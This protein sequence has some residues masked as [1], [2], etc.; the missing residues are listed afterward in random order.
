MSIFDKLVV[1]TLPFVPR[2]FVRQVANRY[3]AGTTLDDAMRVVRDLN[4]QGCMATLDVLGEHITNREEAET[5][6]QEYIK[7]LHRIQS[8]KVDSNISVK[9]TLL[10]LKLSVDFCLENMRRLVQEAK[11][12]NNFVRIDMED[13]SCT[14]DTLKIYSELRKDF[15]NVGFVIQAYLRRSVRDIREQIRLNGKINVRVCKGIYVEPRQIAYK[16]KQ[17]I[18]MN[19]M[20]L[21]EELLRHGNYVG[22]A[23]HDEKLVWSSY[24]LIDELKLTPQEYEFQML[25]GVDEPLRRLILQDGHRLRVYVPYGKRWYEYSVRRLKENP[26]IAGYVARNFFGLRSSNH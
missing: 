4:Q 11:N 22:I 13:S 1:W 16:D 24:R 12:L 23:T 5:A 8:E 2:F 26:K 6:V 20:W 3:I 18:N 19:F 25:L 10:G 7:A 15:T 17:I 14:T 9:L 21:V